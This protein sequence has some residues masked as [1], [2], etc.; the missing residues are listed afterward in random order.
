MKL[1][2]SK[3]EKAMQIAQTAERKLS[4]NEKEST[5]KVISTKQI[6]NC[7]INHI[8]NV[9]FEGLKITKNR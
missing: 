1:S 7:R 9:F 6:E 5:S 4:A 3:E 2:L 8:K